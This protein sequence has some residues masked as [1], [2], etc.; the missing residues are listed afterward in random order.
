MEKTQ[1]LTIEDVVPSQPEESHE[2]PT[3]VP[4]KESDAKQLRALA[5]AYDGVA[6]RYFQVTTPAG[7]KAKEVAQKRLETLVNGLVSA[8]EKLN[9][10]V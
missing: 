9:S 1:K 2:P 10:N 3:I 5:S 7:K 8:A 6:A 4:N